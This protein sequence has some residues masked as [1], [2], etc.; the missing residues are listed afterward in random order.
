[1]AHP[2]ELDLPDPDTYDIVINEYQR[3]LILKAMR[4]LLATAELDANEASVGTVLAGML[5][6]TVDNPMLTQGLNSFVL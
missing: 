6:T 3:A 4:H 5:T 1:M 2:I